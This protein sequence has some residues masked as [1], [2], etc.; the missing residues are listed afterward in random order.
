MKKL[1]LL[2]FVAAAMGC[3]DT[4]TTDGG[5]TC[6]GKCD[7][8]NASAQTLADRLEGRNDPVANFLRE[9]AP[10]DGV[11]DEDYRWLLDGVAA[12]M[13]CVPEQ[14]QT[15]VILM[16][17][18]NYFPRN[19]VTHCSED[20]TKASTFF[21]STQSDYGDLADVNPR[22]FKAAAWDEDARRYNLYE[23]K[24]DEEDG[25]VWADVNPQHCAACH[26]AAVDL[27]VEEYPW[28]PIMNEL[29]N[30]WTLWNAEPDFRSHRF[31]ELIDPAVE[32]APVYSEMTA[33]SKL[34]SAA[35]F[36][37]ISRASLDRVVSARLRARRGEADV[38]AGLDLLRPMFCDETVNYAS[39]NHDTGEIATS[40]VVDNTIA[41]LLKQI[42]PNDWPYDWVNDQ[43][44]RFRSSDLGIEPLAV[45]PVRGELTRQVE[46]G[47]VSRGVLT[48]RQ[49]LALRGLDWQRPVF[50]D[51]R[52]NL[53]RDGRERIL[54]NPPELDG[55]ANLN[56]LLPELFELLMHY[57]VLDPETGETVVW[58]LAPSTPEAVFSLPDATDQAVQET[59]LYGLT[60][61]FETDI[62][63]LASDIED[64]VSTLQEASARDVVEAERVRRG[65]RVAEVIPSAPEVPDIDCSSST[66]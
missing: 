32:Q 40:A 52:C 48:P 63:G 23:F 66:N 13:G 43:R 54:A 3:S 65:C 2:A 56:G 61:E 24:A 6:V 55:F 12:E 35:D 36:E 57:E 46:I 22:D 19:I 15:F 16:S 45:M 17:K 34:A 21:M 44:L 7:G 59:L 20:P 58:P 38:Q 10:S 47:L 50:S 9:S 29:T 4:E 31:D 8:P 18:K 39:E 53:Y 37:V 28:A 62:D 11:I 25:P 27:D 5:E 30:P 42:R 33:P 64:H 51:F 49:A 1:F 14:E 60:E 41:D 26:A